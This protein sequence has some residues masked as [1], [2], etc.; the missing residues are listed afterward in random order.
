[1]TMM[2]STLAVTL[3][4]HLVAGCAGSGRAADEPSTPP[5]QEARTMPTVELTAREPAAAAGEEHAAS[6]A[7]SAEGFTVTGTLA[8]P[9]PC[10]RLSASVTEARGEVDLRV[11]VRADPDA[12]CA[13]VIAS[14]GY[15]ARV[16]GLPAGEYSVRVVHTY[17]DSGWDERTVLTTTLTVR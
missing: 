16:R 1:M 6:A 13:Q 2:R 11:A 9:T 7:P 15:T 17:P 3:A 5:Q 12:I 8:A 4:V 14:L 10:H